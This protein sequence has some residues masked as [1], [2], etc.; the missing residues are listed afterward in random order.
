MRYLWGF[1]LI[2]L[3]LI[4]WGGQLL[5]WAMPDHAVRLG[6]MEA[7][8][9]VEP[10]FWADMRGEAGWDALTL[11]TLPA[12]GALLAAGIDSWALLGLVGGGMYC[13]FAG[14]GI[15]T[16]LAMRRRGLRIGAPANVRVGLAALA[17]WGVAALITI[18]AAATEI[19]A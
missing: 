13:Y 19:D 5:S 15:V 14:R 17:L 3:G 9:D 11:W 10:T 6:L 4:A 12:A 1:V 8:A 18:V 2:V 7:E 16:R